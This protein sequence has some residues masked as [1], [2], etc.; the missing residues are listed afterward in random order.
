MKRLISVSIPR[1]GHHLLVQLLWNYFK[2]GQFLYCEAYTY[3]E[4]CGKVPCNAV[5]QRARSEFGTDLKLRLFMQKS[6]DLDNELIVEPSARYIVQLRDPAQAAI[7]FLRWEMTRGSRDNF[8]LGEIPK[9]VFDFLCYYVRFYHKWC[10]PVMIG[11]NELDTFIIQYERLVGSRDQTR[12]ILL[13]LLA[14]LNLP[15]EDDSLDYSLD[16]SLN[17]DAHTREV[18]GHDAQLYDIEYYDRL[19]GGSLRFLLDKLAAFCPGLP[20]PF[21][22][23]GEGWS[24]PDLIDQQM[25][26]LFFPIDLSSASVAALDFKT[27]E[28]QLQ[29]HSLGVDKGY[30]PLCRSLGLSYGEKGSGAWTLGENVVFPFR[31][32]PSPQR[33]QG[34][35]VVVDRDHRLNLGK[36]LTLSAVLQGAFAPVRTSFSSCD[37]YTL[38]TFDFLAP[39]STSSSTRN[40]ALVLRI[41]RPTFS[42]KV[43]GRSLNLLLDSLTLST[44]VVQAEAGAASG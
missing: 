6:H 43:S 25:S 17:V 20:T 34:K 13:Q 22:G 18:R 40:S 39:Q 23:S 12:N 16:K 3:R 35:I 24:T 1:S 29:R 21:G 19:C 7:G 10:V 30:P 11:A 15:I 38:L 36:L 9:T 32:S 33:V 44:G 27:S 28:R 26:D 31:I 4:C 14:W 41:A 8:S 5:S 2:H 42:G 37:G